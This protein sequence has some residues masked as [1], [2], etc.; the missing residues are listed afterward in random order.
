MQHPLPIPAYHTS[1]GCNTH[2]LLC[3][4]PPLPTFP[5]HFPS[6]CSERARSRQSKAFSARGHGVE[7]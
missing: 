7:T 6:T 5:T 3:P 1:D 4:P 2:C